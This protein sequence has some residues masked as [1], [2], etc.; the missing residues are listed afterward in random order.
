MPEE[1]T[2]RHHGSRQHQNDQRQPA[3]K[4]IHL[5]DQRR[6]PGRDMGQQPADPAHLGGDT[7]R[8]H[9]AQPLTADHQRATEGH[10]AAFGQLRPDGNRVGMFF[11]RRR[12][13]GE[14]RFLNA[15]PMALQKPQIGRD[16]IPGFQQH[17]VPGHQGLD[18][19]PASPAV[20]Q[21]RR[22]RCQQLL[23][24]G[25]RPLGTMLLNQADDGIDDDDG[26]DD[27]RIHD[28]AEQCRDQR[29]TQQHVDQHVVELGQE[30]PG[31]AALRGRRQPVCPVAAQT[32]TSLIAAQS[33]HG[34]IQ[35]A[36]HPVRGQGMP[37]SGL[38][39]CISRR[40]DPRVG[41]P[42]FRHD[43]AG[44]IIAAQPIPGHSILS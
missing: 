27:R 29:R 10:A 5:P 14:H 24:G 30:L 21:H 22:V 13:A 38:H 2:Q 35:L 3:G 16:P 19:H 32:D 41:Y 9:D 12:F 36:Q 8:H 23:D 33:G 40:A 20:T 26:K 18:F 28:M 37:L 25:Q 42:G 6:G 11:H 4:A 39:H 44:A 43:R 1:M 31:Q 17:D 7:R 34:R 15:Q